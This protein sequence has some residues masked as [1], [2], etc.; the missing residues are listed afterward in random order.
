MICRSGLA[1]L[2]VFLWEIALARTGGELARPKLFSTLV[3]KDVEMYLGSNLDSSAG[4]KLKVRDN[5]VV[6][7]AGIEFGESP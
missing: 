1:G 7:V 5:V 2:R 4:R 6:V 3:L